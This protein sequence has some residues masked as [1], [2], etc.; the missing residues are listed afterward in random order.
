MSKV[1]SFSDD[2]YRDVP[3]TSSHGF[4]SGE[5]SSK[6]AKRATSNT[7]AYSEVLS[8]DRIITSRALSP[9]IVDEDNTGSNTEFARIF[10][11]KFKSFWGQ[12]IYPGKK[13]EEI[14]LIEAGKI[15]LDVTPY[16]TSFEII[17]GYVGDV[18]CDDFPLQ[19][20]DPLKGKDFYTW[21]EKMSLEGG[22]GCGLCE[23]FEL[24]A[25]RAAR[26]MEMPNAICPFYF[27]SCDEMPYLHVNENKVRRFLNSSYSGEL[28]TR[29]VYLEL[30]K[31]VKGNAFILVNPYKGRYEDGEEKNPEIT[32]EVIAG[33]KKV[34]P[35]QYHSHIIKLELEKSV[36]DV[37]LG[38][39]ARRSG[40]R[41][42]AGY[43]RDMVTKGQ[44]VDRIEMVNRM[45]SFLDNVNVKVGQ[46]PDN[47]V[48]D[49]DSCGHLM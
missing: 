10:Y 34:I 41:D 15:P 29:D 25:L 32:Q 33:W 38:I 36:V 45:L 6:E 4:S 27:M 39:I 5:T 2:Y 7:N 40:A 17:F 14:A 35:S 46:M 8:L 12:I 9:I 3:R 23:S 48:E 1:D 20:T 30:F 13:V 19:H 49:M 24:G 37:M 44:S 16:L 22:G 18:N 47:D 43:T 21:I 31:K 11:D 28:N 42:K 26:Y